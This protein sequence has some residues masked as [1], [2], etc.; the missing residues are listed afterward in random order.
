MQFGDN[1]LNDSH[2]LPEM[3]QI[4]G[5]DSFN[6]MS[7]RALAVSVEVPA[8]VTSRVTCVWWQV[9]RWHQ[10]T[11]VVLIITVSACNSADGH[12]GLRQTC[13]DAN[14]DPQEFLRSTD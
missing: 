8:V 12:G 14:A 4:D 3:P 5:R 2:L 7:H 10:M 1:Y 13:A 9:R 11:V 6:S